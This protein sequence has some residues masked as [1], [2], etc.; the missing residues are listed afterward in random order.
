MS[1]GE[2]KRKRLNREEQ[3]FRGFGLHL[4]FIKVRRNGWEAVPKSMIVAYS[5][6]EVSEQ[7][8]EYRGTRETPWEDRGTT[9]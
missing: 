9:L 7:Y 8:P 5:K 1:S 2:R 4:A 3:S 6:T